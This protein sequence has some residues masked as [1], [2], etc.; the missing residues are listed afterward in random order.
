MSVLVDSSIWIN[1]LHR[2]APVLESLLLAGEVITHPAIIGE[3]ACGSLKNRER[4][5][6][7]LQHLS[8]LPQA[9]FKDV[10]D[11]IESQQLWG[12]GLGWMDAQLLAAA[13]QSGVTIWT[14]DRALHLAAVRS[15]LAFIP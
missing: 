9:E 1:H 8:R 3:L 14:K 5:L 4:F 6:T 15:Q 7:S 10:L 2:S 11:L 13:L 12:K